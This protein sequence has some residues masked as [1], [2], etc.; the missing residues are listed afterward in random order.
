MDCK[1]CE[2][3]KKR[4]NII[5]E[6]ST[7]YAFLLD[8]PVAAG[9]IVLVPKEH[10]PIIEKIPDETMSHLFFVAN[11]LSSLCFQ[12]LRAHG[13]NILIQNGVAAGQKTTHAQIHIIP[14]YENDGLNL[15]WQPIKMTEDDLSTAQLMLSDEVEKAQD[16]PKEEKEIKEEKKEEKE[17]IPDNENYMLLQLERQP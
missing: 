7:S 8:A 14:R 5:Y 10:N 11:K 1:E 15:Q 4:K 17:I 9:H 12:T 16:Q 6:D 13:T 3:I 2:I